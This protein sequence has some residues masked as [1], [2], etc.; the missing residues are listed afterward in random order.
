MPAC[1]WR[2]FWQRMREVADLPTLTSDGDSMLAENRTEMSDSSLSRAWNKEFYS[3]DTWLRMCSDEEVSRLLQLNAIPLKCECFSGW[4]IIT[5]TSLLWSQWRCRHFTIAQ[6]PLCHQTVT[7]D[8]M[9]GSDCF[10]G[11]G[12]SGSIRLFVWKKCY[13]SEWCFQAS[14]DRVI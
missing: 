10:Q 5:S 3:C 4:T 12:L 8:E 6:V 11:N 14:G 9:L 1:T 2:R 13:F 7:L